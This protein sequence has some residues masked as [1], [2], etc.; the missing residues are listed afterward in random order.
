MEK[1][2][3]IQQVF[4]NVLENRRKFTA[5]SADLEYA[6]LSCVEELAADGGQPENLYR[7][8]DR[9]RVDNNQLPSGHLG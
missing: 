6:R 4:V 7:L 5:R 8:L 9:N 1:R 3:Q 2:D